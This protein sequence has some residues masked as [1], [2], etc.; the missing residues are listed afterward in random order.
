M[1]Q[2]Q[3]LLFDLDGTLTDPAEGITNSVAHALAK[4]GITNTDRRELY[5]FIGPP[6][7]RSFLEYAHLP[8]EEV[9]NAVAYYREYY[10]EKGIHECY[11]YDGILALLADLRDAGYTL[12]V[13]TSKALPFAHQVLADFGLAPYFDYVSGSEL[14]GT[15]VDKREVVAEAMRMANITDASKALMI[16]DRLHDIVGAKANGIDSCGVLYG[17]GSADEFTEHGATYTVTDVDALRR[18]LL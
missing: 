15:R 5:C 10:S 17:Y 12:I 1:R 16:G 9:D 8:P 13:A 14:D 2:Y 11:V 6:L 18:M 4:Y 3:Y 7:I